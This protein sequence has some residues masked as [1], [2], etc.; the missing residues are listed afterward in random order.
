MSFA[1]PAKQETETGHSLMCSAHGCPLK[2]SVKIDSP[3]CRYHAFEE[4]KKWP[5]ITESI[6]RYGPPALPTFTGSRTVQEMK[7]RMR[8]GHRF[9]S[10]EERKAA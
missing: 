5:A 10:L 4:E 2:W 3:L 7:S 8:P 9:T 1:K 6:R